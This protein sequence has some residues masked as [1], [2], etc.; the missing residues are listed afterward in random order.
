MTIH[1]TAI[2]DPSAEIADDARIGAY[3]VI[4]PEVKIGSNTEVMHHVSIHKLTTIGSNCVIWPFA[5]LGTDPQ[6]LKFQGER[7]TL[8]IGDN[9]MIRECATANRGTADG[10]L[11]T[12]IGA[13][14][15]LMAYAHVAHDCQ[16]GEG[17]IMAN[18]VNLAG[19]VILGERCS[20]GGMTAVHQFTRVGTRCFVG[21][22]SGISKDLPP[23]CLCEGNRAKP[24]GINVIGL[25]RSGFSD[26]S[27]TALK[28]AY[29]IIFRTRTPI[30]KAIEQV[31]QEVADAVEV[32]TLLQFIEESERG[33]SR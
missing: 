24:H 30:K 6:D 18:A 23:Y 3:S 2:I 31:R 28:D 32:R 21:G 15:L 14:C 11:V 29:R 12:R 25:K 19:H 1:P 17:V 20:I 10:G 4:G 16:L 22:M 9:V 7:S 5:S 8:E 13:N 33:V 26:E 27:I